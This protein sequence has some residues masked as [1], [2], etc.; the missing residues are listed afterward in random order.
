LKESEDLFEGTTFSVMEPPT[1]P[2]LMPDGR[3]GTVMLSMETTPSTA[4]YSM[5]PSSR[6]GSEEVASEEEELPSPLLP[7]SPSSSTS[8]SWLQIISTQVA[9]SIVS[10]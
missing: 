4:W 6:K 5:V 2:F 7:D 9:R 10:T 3:L 1:D 8:T